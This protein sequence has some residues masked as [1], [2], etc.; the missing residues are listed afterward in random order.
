MN[1]LAARLTSEGRELFRLGFGQSPF[2]APDEVVAALRDNAHRCDYLPVRGLPALREAIAAHHTR[3]HGAT[4][5]ADNVVVGP[6]S[7]Q[8]MYL[9]QLVLDAVTIVP[10]PAWV[11]YVPQAR[12][13]SRPCV[14]VPT[15]IDDG[16]RL[17]PAALEAT[18]REAAGDQGQL[19]T[20][21]GGGAGRGAPGASGRLAA[22]LPLLILNYPGNPTGTTYQESDLAALAEV[23]ERHDLLVLSDEIYGDLDHRGQHVSMARFYPDGT[24]VTS[25][26]SKWCGAGGWRLGC[27]LVPD[28][29]SRV[30]DAVAAAA[31][32]TYSAA[33]TPVQH[34]ALQAYR[35]SSEITAGLEAQRRI[36]ATLGSWCAERLGAAS[37]RTCKPQGGFYLFPDFGVLADRLA[38]RGIDTSDELARRL[39][40]ETGVA[41]LPGSDFGRPPRELA[42][43]LAYVDFD[44]AAALRAC[45]EREIDEG[46]LRQHCGRVLAAIESMCEWVGR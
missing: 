34:A 28:A 19:A 20:A 32:E 35:G 2:P 42:L 21:N 40:T 39:L 15:A 13:A 29:L 18:C 10:T 44:G 38:E 17:T 4:V 11:S 5:K 8:L 26:L 24:L 41:T 12:L 27:L 22:R 16:W 7:K 9:V 25:G 30:G 14:T 1:E 46:F 3:L 23:A 45:A 37:V 31:S 36:L 6:G 43:R 33:S